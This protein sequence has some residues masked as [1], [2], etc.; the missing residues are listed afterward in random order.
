M[1]DSPNHRRCSRCYKVFHSRDAAD[2]H[3]RDFHKGKGERIPVRRERHE[4]E[5]DRIIESIMDGKPPG[6]MKW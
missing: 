6:W 3:I 5:A 1:T 2:Q 4:S